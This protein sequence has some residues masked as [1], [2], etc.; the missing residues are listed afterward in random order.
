MPENEEEQEEKFRA[1]PRPHK[2]T[3]LTP[4]KAKRGKEFKARQPPGK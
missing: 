4:M 3:G 1:A 2:P